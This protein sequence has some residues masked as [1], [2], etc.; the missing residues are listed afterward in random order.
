MSG[1]FVFTFFIFDKFVFDECVEHSFDPHIIVAGVFLSTSAYFSTP[2]KLSFYDTI[3]PC[4]HHTRRL[5]PTKLARLNINF[6]RST[7]SVCQ[8]GRRLFLVRSCTARSTLC[9]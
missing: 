4:E 2:V 6:R 7:R 5:R 8:K 1:K 3:P 9:S